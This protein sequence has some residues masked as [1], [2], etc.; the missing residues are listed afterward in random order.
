MRTP[1]LL[2]VLLLAAA[3]SS[4]ERMSSQNLAFRYQNNVPVAV[5]TRVL[6][7]GDHLRLYLRIDARKLGADATA[8][9]LAERYRFSYRITPSYKSRQTIKEVAD[10]T[11]DATHGRDAMGRFYASITVDKYPTP[12]VLLVLT[13]TERAT[14][15]AITFDVPLYPGQETMEQKYA[16]FGLNRSYP[17]VDDFVT[18]AD[19]VVIR[20]LGT[21][22]PTL[23]VRYFSNAFQP[24]LPPM[25]LNNAV[26]QRPT[27]DQLY[28]LRPGEV[29]KFAAT[30]LYFAQE[31]TNG[32]DGFSFVVSPRR[33]PDLTRAGQLI[34]PLIYIST[35][36]ERE[37]LLSANNA[38]LALD[39]FWLRLAN[40]NKDY[41]RRMI[42]AYYTRVQ[43]ANAQFTTFKT[44]WMTD[45]GMIYVVFGPPDKLLRFN[46][47]EEWYYQKR[48][49][50]NEIYFT[51]LRRP[52]IFTD[53][54]YELVRYNE[55]DRIW[56]GNVEQWRKGIGIASRAAE[57]R[58]TGTNGRR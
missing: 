54:N 7:E 33:Y 11:F 43:E 38:K 3:C 45:Q 40:N 47:R 46:D 30:G 32:R 22:A 17:V 42:R 13:A 48:G 51:F 39:Q 34:E 57:P 2:L 21:A 12:A 36:R 1:L 25:A 15:K 24:A 53:E 6:D 52:T 37:Q 26:R 19:T 49:N 9:Q 27:E 14:D 4:T 55:Y 10:L 41:A 35:R 23:N 16:L 44:G 50:T 56:Y 31:D 5:D 8:G 28:F 18:T 20:S 29:M 58:A